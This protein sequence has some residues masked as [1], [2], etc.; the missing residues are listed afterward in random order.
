M[1]LNPDEAARFRAWLV[2]A[3]NATNPD[4]LI[5]TLHTSGRLSERLSQWRTSESTPGAPSA[6]QGADARLVGRAP[7]VVWPV[8]PVHPHG[9]GD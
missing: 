8:R 5:V 7:G 1:M 4:G 6:A 3:T 2:Q 9:D